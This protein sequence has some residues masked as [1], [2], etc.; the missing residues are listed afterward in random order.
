[1]MQGA[2]PFFWEP[3]ESKKTGVGILLIHGWT[4]SPFELQ[5]LGKYLLGKGLTVSAPLLPGH[6]TVAEDLYFV[7]WDNWTEAIENSYQEL[8]KKTD[9]IFVAGVSMGGNLAIHL[10]SDH[11]EIRGVITMGAPLFL[12]KHFLR[13]FLP[14]WERIHPMTNKSYPDYVRQEILVNKRHYWSFP[15][16]S[17]QDAIDGMNDSIKNLHK[18]KCPA[19]VMQST[20]DHL[21][22]ARNARVLFRKLGT[23]RKEKEL[24]WVHDSDHVFIIDLYQEEIF[25]KTYDFVL[26]HID[27]L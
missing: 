27:I 14:I 23:S 20:K 6:G 25:Q 13:F 26:S 2:E 22:T 9:K 19:L 15:T 11:L 10:A 5:K 8:K 16:K 3:E 12:R 24:V 4:S 1:M 17:I 18:I 21:L 7:E